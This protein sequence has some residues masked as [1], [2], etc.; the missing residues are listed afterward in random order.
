MTGEVW[1]MVGTVHTNG[2]E[3]FWSWMP[4]PRTWPV[5]FSSRSESAIG[6][7]SSAKALR[8]YPI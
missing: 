6:S 2:I 8:H 5:R 4:R 1:A 7:P 3:S